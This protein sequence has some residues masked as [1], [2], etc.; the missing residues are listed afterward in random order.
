MLSPQVKKI[1]TDYFNEYLKLNPLFATFIGMH[2]YDD[3]LPD[4]YSDKYHYKEKTFY[5]RYLTLINNILP[6]TQ[7]DYINIEAFRDLMLLK[8]EGLH[9]PFRELPITQMDNIFLS[10]MSLVIESGF[11]PLNDK[12]DL[13]R[14]HERMSN[15]P[16][17]VASII[18]KMN[19][20]IKS[21]R[22]LPK[23]I[24]T[25]VITQLN[26][27][28]Q[29]KPY[30]ICRHKLS[31]RL[32]QQLIVILETFLI[33]PLET[34]IEFL[35]REYLG[36]ARESYGYCDIPMGDEMYQYLVKISTTKYDL[37]IPKIHQLGIKETKRIS[38]A[39]KLQLV[40]LPLKDFTNNK[41]FYLTSPDK[42][43]QAYK[44]QKQSINDYILPKYFGKLRP[45]VDYEIIQ[46]PK[47]D[48][49]FNST[50]YYRS[51][52]IDNTRPGAFYVN[53]RNLKEHPTYNMEVLTLHEGN[54]GHHY[55]ISL[56]QDNPDIP[57]FRSFDG[58]LYNAYIE[59][60]GLYCETL[61]EYQDGYSL[62][63]RYDYE[64]IRAARLVIDT[65]IHYYGWTFKK[66]RDYLGK[67]SKMAESDLDA[68]IYRYISIPG[69]ALSYKIGEL[70]IL[71]CRDKLV[72]KY[73]DNNND[74]NGNN[75]NNDNEDIIK[76]H[77]KIIELG[78]VPLWLL[79]V[80]LI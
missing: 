37:T 34:M 3:K 11:Q 9:L 55:Q 59:G 56:S 6:I 73:N 4:Y 51:P 70:T 50:A 41:Q 26:D 52:S 24:V 63:G 17:L 18:I 43:L 75:N 77:Q 79:E 39:M 71:S 15:F 8:L 46:V 21:G 35:K 12:P 38:K 47:F 54:P 29:D 20:G 60:W 72:K 68:E 67:V 25:Q 22:V 65:G 32:Y 31:K 42:V 64:I 5:Q 36:K 80:G 19:E 10:V 7:L 62:M 14:F 45:S 33:P 44:D 40:K 66:A 13:A 61:G 30:T 74:G 2:E 16:N 48:E 27:I 28:L 49:K 76:F 23:K 57:K 53:M 69:Q 1:F 58:G 78:P